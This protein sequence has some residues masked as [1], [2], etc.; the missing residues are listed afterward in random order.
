MAP[1]ADH[2]KDGLEGFAALE[3]YYDQPKRVDK[4]Y[5]PHTHRV[6]KKQPESIIICK[7]PAPVSRIYGEI[8]VLVTECTSEKVNRF[9]STGD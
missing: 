9:Y 4:Q 6:P 5:I 7:M 2:V 1:Q 8:V 3:E